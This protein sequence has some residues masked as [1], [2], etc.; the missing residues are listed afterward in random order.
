MKEPVGISLMQLKKVKIKGGGKQ[1]LFNIHCGHCDEFVLVYLKIGK[2]NNI[3]RAY[4]SRI[5]A[6]SSLA[7]LIDDPAIKR[8]QDIPNLSC[9][10]CQAILGTPIKRQDGRLA[11]RL[12]QG[13]F[14][15]KIRK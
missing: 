4:L 14:H 2:G 8:P 3:L 12:K 11:F 6:P 1:T 13:H 9:P 5:L 7:S 15:R 10:N